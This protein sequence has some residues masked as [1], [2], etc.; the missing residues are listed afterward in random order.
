MLKKKKRIRKT[1][2]KKLNEDLSKVTIIQDNKIIP[3][4]INDKMNLIDKNWIQKWNENRK[5]E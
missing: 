1:K 5:F 3:N 2:I 4:I